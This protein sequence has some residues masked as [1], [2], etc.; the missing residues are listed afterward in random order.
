MKPKL[1]LFSIITVF[2]FLSSC[3]E[4]KKMDCTDTIIEVNHLE[5]EYGCTDV[6][7]N[8]S[9]T[10]MIITSPLDYSE[11]VNANCELDIDFDTYELVIGKKGLTNG[12]SSIEYEL[13][14]NCETENQNLKITFHLNDTT[15]APNITYNALI[16]KLSDNQEL[17]VEIVLVN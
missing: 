12:L 11:F 15:E 1:L 7:V 13:V 2:F 4:N 8:L 3:N 10:Y 6:D 17:H 16:P 9:D 14:E 5:N